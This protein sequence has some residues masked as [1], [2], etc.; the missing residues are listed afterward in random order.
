MTREDLADTLKNQEM[1]SKL[2]AKDTD[3]AQKRLQLAV[4]RFSTEK[5]INKALGEGAYQNLTQLSAQ[6]KIAALIDKVKGAFQ[7]FLTK[8]GVVEWVTGLIQKLTDPKNVK[9][10]INTLKEGVA[11]VADMIQGIAIGIVKIADIFTDIDPALIKRL[12]GTSAGDS[13]R[14]MG[15]G[16]VAVNDFVIKPMNEDTI[17][18][19]GGTKLGRTDEMV[20]VLRQILNETKQGKS[21]TVSVD[22]QPL[23]VAVARNAS[24]TQAASN[25]GPRPLR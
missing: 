13:I 19:A 24:L 6:E 25:L 14:S 3:N 2:G 12:E 22:G 1:L 15:T 18:M 17:T 4:A 16:T 10:L 5:E 11:F 8:S 21:V 9:G 20:D 23:A 7:D